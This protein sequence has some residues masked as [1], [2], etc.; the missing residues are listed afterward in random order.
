MPHEIAPGVLSWASELDEATLEQAARTARLPILAGPIALMPDAHLGM[1]ATVGSVIPTETAVIPSAVGVDIGCGM[2]ARRLDV[3]LG[4]ARRTP[5]WTAGSTR[6]A[7]RCPR[8]LGRLARRGLDRRPL[9]LARRATRRRRRA[10]PEARVAAAARHA[11]L[12]QPLRRARRRRG[13][14]G[15]GCCCT[16]GRGRWATSSRSTA[17]RRSRGGCTRAWAPSSR[18]PTSRTCSEGDPGVRRLHP[19]PAVGAGLR[20]RQPASR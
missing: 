3:R 2:I 10:R 18:T 5:G 20:A 6:C 8:A 12:G 15:R 1:G 14:P 4:P 16:P 19:R 7:G 11:G 13:G 17:H 9:E